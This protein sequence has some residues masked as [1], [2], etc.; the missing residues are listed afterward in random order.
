MITEGRILAPTMR[1][2]PP[3]HP[4]LK[5]WKKGLG[6]GEREGTPVATVRIHSNNPHPF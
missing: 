4:A 5:A 1:R 3:P 2:V 6:R